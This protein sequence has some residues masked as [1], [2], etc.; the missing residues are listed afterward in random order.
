MEIVGSNPTLTNI[1]FQITL[2]TVF[3][4]Q[5]EKVCMLFTISQNS[6]TFKMAEFKMD[7]FF[8]G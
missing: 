5:L 2:H 3:L 8:F 6:N 1:D 4:S 7:E